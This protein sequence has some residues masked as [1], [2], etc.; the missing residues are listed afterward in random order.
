MCG[1]IVEGSVSYMSISV[2][3][4]NVTIEAKVEMMCLLECATGKERRWPIEA[5]KGKKQIL[6]RDSRRNI[7]LLML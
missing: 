6:P 5:A 3:E 7:P 1:Y 2:K 4:R